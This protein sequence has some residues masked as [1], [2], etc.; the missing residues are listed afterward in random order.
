MKI[1]FA[2]LIMLSMVGS[3]GADSL[4]APGPAI[5]STP[6][7]VGPSLGDATTSFKRRLSSHTDVITFQGVKGCPYKISFLAEGGDD[8]EEDATPF[9]AVVRKDPVL[10]FLIISKNYSHHLMCLSSNTNANR[11]GMLLLKI[12]ICK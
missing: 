7:I 10:L 1:L 12:L 5:A 11:F 9:D 6:D 3:S 4:R 8:L 2:S